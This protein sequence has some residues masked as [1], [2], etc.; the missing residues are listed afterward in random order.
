MKVHD[1]APPRGATKSRKR[2]GRGNGSG[3]GGTCGRGQNGQRS[4]AGFSQRPW[5]EGGQTPLY[6]RLPK[7]GFKP[8]RRTRYAVVNLRS[9]EGFAAGATVGPEEL[10]A[11]QL[12]PSANALVKI[13]A[14]GDIAVSLT[15]RAHKFSGASAPKIVAAGGQAEVIA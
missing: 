5:F 3:R 15:V 13:L 4:R 8:I 2:L 9:L 11:Q 10:F 12:I 6:R 14:D 7:R 1:L